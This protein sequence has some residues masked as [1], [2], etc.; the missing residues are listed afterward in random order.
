MTKT[1]GI[2]GSG[3]AGLSAALYTLRA[4]FPTTLFGGPVEGG[5]VTTTETVDNYLGLP[6]VGGVELSGIFLKHAESLG[7]ELVHRTVATIEK[8][9]EDFRILTTEEE[10]FHFDA[11]IF[12]AG[13]VP[14]KLGIPGEDFS[15][16]SWCATCDGAFFKGDPVAVVG[17]GE[18]AVEEALYLSSLASSVTVLLRGEKFRATQPAVNNLL[19]R[20]NVKARYGVAVESIIGDG[21]VDGLKLSD[22]SEL[23]VYGLF[24]AIGQVP[25]SHTA[26]KHT[27]LFENGY[28]HREKTEG[29][30]AAGDIRNPEHRQ[31]AVAVG[32]G[33][34]A[35]M[36]AIKWLQ[37]R[38][39]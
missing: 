4:G 22:G 6:G 26:Q 19:S 17:G 29:F 8:T 13:S 32:D 11:L 36:D 28:V 10:V 12:A 3:P 27:V 14:R 21:Q 24:E 1:V 5:L 33:A 30:F 38:V 7:A 2:V 16:V 31:I 39:D 37:T 15:G 34:R 35:A 25:Q 18:A 23:P 9:S 20:S